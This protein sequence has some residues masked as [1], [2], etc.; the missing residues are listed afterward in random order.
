MN[1]LNLSI[2]TLDSENFLGSDPVE[3]ATWLCLLR[4]CN[5]WKN[6]RIDRIYINCLLS[7]FHILVPLKFQN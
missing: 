5:N 7:S 1:W 6:H 3:R 2:Q 4:Y